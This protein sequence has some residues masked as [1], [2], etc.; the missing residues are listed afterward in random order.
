MRMLKERPVALQRDLKLEEP[1][2]RW[3]LFVTWLL[4]SLTPAVPVVSTTGASSLKSPAS[5]WRGVVFVALIVSV[6]LA[7]NI[8]NVYAQWGNDFDTN[9][10]VSNNQVSEYQTANDCAAQIERTQIISDGNGGTVI[11]F[12]ADYTNSNKHDVYLN[13]VN[14]EGNFVWGNVAPLNITN[15]SSSRSSQPSL[16]IDSNNDAIFV[17]WV[18]YPSVH[19]QRISLNSGSIQWTVDVGKTNSFDWRWHNLGISSDGV[20]GVYVAWSN[21]DE[22][23]QVKRIDSS[24][25]TLWTNNLGDVGQKQAL[26]SLIGNENGAYLVFEDVRNNVETIRTMYVDANG[27]FLWTNELTGALISTSTGKKG[28]PKAIAANNGDIIIAWGHANG[29][30]GSGIYAQR[31]NTNGEKLWATDKYVMN[32]S[33]STSF[34]MYYDGEQAIFARVEVS[35]QVGVQLLDKDGV[36]QWG[37]NGKNITPPATDPHFLHFNKPSIIS[38]NDGRKMEKQFLRGKV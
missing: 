16:V 11:G 19:V 6:F 37:N 17:T 10:P 22:V 15:D 14:S 5:V 24:G 25:A 26:G 2:N 12:N 30:S 34:D 32:G 29:G 31:L 27:N 38:N 36:R 28:I 7:L 8:S 21:V 35:Y 9:V 33:W 18:E 20:G 23:I 13:R 3:Q 4:E 1:P